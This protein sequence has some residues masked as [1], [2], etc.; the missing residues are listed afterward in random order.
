V[1]DLDPKGF[2]ERRPKKTERENRFP[3]L[4][5]RSTEGRAKGSRRTR[6][7]QPKFSGGRGNDA[8]M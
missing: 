3:G 6:E 1:Y 8:T 2:G 5:Y 7:R 4:G